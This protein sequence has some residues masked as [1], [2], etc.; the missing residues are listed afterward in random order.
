[1]RRVIGRLL[2]ACGWL[3]WRVG[4]LLPL[5]RR[6][7]VRGRRVGATLIGFLLLALAVVPAI[8]PLLDAQP[9]AVTVQQIMDGA[10][11]EPSGWVRLAGA[12]Y[13]LP[14]TPTGTAGAYGLLVDAANELRAI[15]LRGDV[16]AARESP[17]NVT[18]H[19]TSASVTVD[20]EALPIDATVFGSPPRIVPDQIVELDAPLKPMRGSL[21]PIGIFPALLGLMTIAG[22]RV[23][24][25]LFRETLEIDV[26]SGPLGPGDRVPAAWGGTV[27]SNVRDLGDPGAALLLVRRGP[28]GNV[29]TAQP[30]SDDGGPAPAPVPISGGWTSGRVGYVYTVTETVP[31]LT[32]R[33]ED[34][35]A[36]FLFAKTTERDRIAALIA[37]QR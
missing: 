24:Y 13:E 22:S 11:T 23:G 8:V 12:T 29:L 31:A 1:M 3:A 32:V 27:G 2:A 37:T 20:V 33:S 6:W 28:N 10:V 18:G 30:L 4:R 9:E 19:L 34:V 35:D 26:L 21:W 5:P 15:V 25:P 14:D 7:R 36:T 17:A 16:E